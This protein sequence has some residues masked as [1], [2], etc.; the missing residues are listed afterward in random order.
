MLIKLKCE[1]CNKPINRAD[2]CIKHTD[3]DEI[4]C[5]VDCAQE[6][7]KKYLKEEA[8]FLLSCSHPLCSSSDGRSGYVGTLGATRNDLIAMIEDEDE[9]EEEKRRIAIYGDSLL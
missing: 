1:H 5:S 8:S 6:D 2:R 4:F 9:D 3:T 7:N